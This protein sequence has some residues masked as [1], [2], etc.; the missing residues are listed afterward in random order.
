MKSG[1]RITETPVRVD[2]YINGKVERVYR[3]IYT[4]SDGPS[5]LVQET[6]T[7]GSGL[8]WAENC[9]CA[10]QGD[11]MENLCVHCRSAIEKPENWTCPSCKRIW[12]FQPSGADQKLIADFKAKY[13]EARCMFESGDIPCGSDKWYIQYG[14]GMLFNMVG[15]WCERSVDLSCSG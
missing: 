10:Q 12:T 7:S 4:D 14:Q 11:L 2:I 6:K 15:P 5:Y 8:S 13:P 9:Q 1:T 3:E